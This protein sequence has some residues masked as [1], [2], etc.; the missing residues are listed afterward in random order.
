MSKPVLVLTEVGPRMIAES[1][2]FYPRT[3]PGYLEDY[4]EE[5]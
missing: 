5:E 4:D 1:E 2:P 3:Y